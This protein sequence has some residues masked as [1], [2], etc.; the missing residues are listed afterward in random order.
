MYGPS[1]CPTVTPRPGMTGPSVVWLG[2]ERVNRLGGEWSF[3][4]IGSLKAAMAFPIDITSR[5]FS[6]VRLCPFPSSAC[7]D[8]GPPGRDAVET[9][10]GLV[11]QLRVLQIINV[12]AFDYQKSDMLRYLDIP[13]VDRSALDPP[14][15]P[16]CRR[17]RRTSCSTPPE[18]VDSYFLVDNW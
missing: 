3:L 5:G 4:S 2:Q 15:A 13:V 1:S 11:A 16:A 17:C 18:S 9:A 6:H 12:G 7:L 14:Y 10:C 8:G